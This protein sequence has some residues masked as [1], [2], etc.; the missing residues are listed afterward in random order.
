MW[1]G[2]GK[3]P[4]ADCWAHGNE[5]SVSI[6]GTWNNLSSS[7][8]ISFLINIQ[9]TELVSE[10]VNQFIMEYRSVPLAY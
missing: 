4:V 9:L 3:D 1:I 10:I 6:K 5:P 2:S 7:V 8:T